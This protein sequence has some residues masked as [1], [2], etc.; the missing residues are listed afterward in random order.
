MNF[1]S[2]L[3]AARTELA[4]NQVP[5][6]PCV[7]V[8]VKIAKAYDVSVDYLLLD[9]APRRSL[10][11][12]VDDA[13]VQRLKDVQALGDEDRAPRSFSPPNLSSRG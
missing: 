13:I 12:P 3:S 4:R 7:E 6:A 9:D 5:P 2:R 8:V 11:E 10:L 1:C